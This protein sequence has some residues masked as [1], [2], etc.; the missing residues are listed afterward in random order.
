MAPLSTAVVA[1]SFVKVDLDRRVVQHAEGGTVGEV[2]VRYGEHAARG[3]V[4]LVLGDCPVAGEIINLKFTTPGSVI[5]PREPIADIV[6]SNPRLV[7]EAR[8]RP[9]DISLVH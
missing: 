9:E 5:S 8:I 6:P 7:L 2:T 1:S 3:Q 4:L